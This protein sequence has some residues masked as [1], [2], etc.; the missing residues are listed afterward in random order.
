M[1]PAV[2]KPAARQVGNTTL[3]RLVTENWL[4]L[5][6]TNDL[7]K[8]AAFEA[9]FFAPSILVRDGG[10]LRSSTKYAVCHRCFATLRPICKIA[11]RQSKFL[12]VC[13][14]GNSNDLV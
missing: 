11:K 14:E 1:L 3:S 6:T 8:T 5:S 13:C 12:W 4:G 2:A 10:A 7:E 9:L